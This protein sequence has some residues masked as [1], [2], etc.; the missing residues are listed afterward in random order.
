MITN[1]ANVHATAAYAGTTVVTAV[2]IHL[3]TNDVEPVEQAVDRT[4][5]TDEAAERTIAEHTEQPDS[6]HDDKLPGKEHT[7]HAELRCVD[8]V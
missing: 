2:L 1:V 5:R 3:D 4:K 6:Q 7:Q 8:G